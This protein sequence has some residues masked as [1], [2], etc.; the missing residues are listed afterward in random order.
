MASIKVRDESDDLKNWMVSFQHQLDSNTFSYI[1]ET[2]IANQFS[3]R[4]NLK[5]IREEEMNSMFQTNLSLSA[6]ALLF[7]QISWL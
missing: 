7:C 4:M 1:Y 3:T 6:K 5:H 2:L